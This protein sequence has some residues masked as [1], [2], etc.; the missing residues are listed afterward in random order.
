MLED[1]W[2]RDVD[3]HCVQFG[4]Q[5]LQHYLDRRVSS[6]VELK[7]VSEILEKDFTLSAADGAS[8]RESDATLH[9]A[10]LKECLQGDPVELNS[11]FWKLR[12]SFAIERTKHGAQQGT[13][14]QSPDGSYATD[15]RSQLFLELTEI[16][17]DVAEPHRAVAR[18]HAIGRI[19]Q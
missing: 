11:V 8:D 16:G 12:A 4:F 13:G 2:W 7:P 9:I 19:A 18:G 15:R 5:T 14:S 3:C 6:A 17:D 1:F 10:S